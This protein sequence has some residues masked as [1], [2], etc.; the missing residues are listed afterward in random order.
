MNV[1]LFSVLFLSINAQY[2]ILFLQSDEMD[3]RVM[4]PNNHLYNVVS[5]P[6]LRALAANGINFINTY[7]NSPLCAPSRA[8]LWAGRYVHTIRTWSNSKSLA[9]LVEDPTKPDPQCA[10]VVG[11]GSQYCVEMGQKQNVNTTIK[12][13]LEL[14]GYN[15]ILYGKMDIG[16]GMGGGFHGSGNWSKDLAK[17]AQCTDKTTNNRCPGNTIQSWTRGANTNLPNILSMYDPHST[18]INAHSSSGGSFTSHDNDVQNSCI[19]FIKEYNKN[20]TSNSKPFLLYCS[21]IEPHPPFHSNKTWFKYINYTALNQTIKDTNF[22]NLS[23]F[24]DADKYETM[25]ENINNV[26][27]NINESWVFDLYRSYFGGCAQLDYNM[28]NII[29]ELK[30]NKELYDNTIIVYTSDHGELH[31]EHRMFEKMS[32]YEG[33]SR[34]PLIVSG[35]GIPKNKIVYDNFTS[36]VDMFPTFLEIANVSREDKI[37][38]KNLNGYSLVPFWNNNVF[39]DR[40]DYAFSEYHGEDTNTA[41]FMIR[42]GNYKL[43]VYA[44]N[45]PFESYKPKLFD[46]VNDE[47]E[48]NDLADKYPDIV[49]NMTDVLQGIVG[50][51]NQ[52]DKICQDEGKTNYL[53][54]KSNYSDNWKQMMNWT[55]IGITDSDITHIDEWGNSN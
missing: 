29:N 53:R 44:T 28:G 3:G 41:Q 36:L 7:T 11:Y 6:N 33:S 12:Q 45:A 40:P 39:N 49:K 50:D 13:S 42:Q 31:L 17:G 43:I 27:I 47:Y 19:K 15:V 51:Y 55:Y 21:M 10:R 18:M 1:L 30:Q 37:Y 14:A 46:V 8:S 52:V 35:P 26:N 34:V 9:A 48:Y 38:P 54:W 4:D 20:K 23:L 2:N 32:M 25:N 16:G 22:G 5:L 24:N